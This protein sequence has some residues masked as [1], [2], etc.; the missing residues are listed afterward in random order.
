VAFSPDGQRLAS[1]S[2]DR[3]VRLWDAT[4]GQEVINLGGHTGAVRSV[5]FSPDGRRLA[6]ASDDTT[7]RLWD[8][9]LG[10]VSFMLEGAW[11]HEG[12]QSLDEDF[13]REIARQQLE[14][15]A[16]EEIPR[17]NHSAASI[18]GGIKYVFER[19]DMKEYRFRGSKTMAIGTGQQSFV[20][21]GDSAAQVYYKVEKR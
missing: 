20:A 9:T 3:T 18:S 12:V 10:L 21:W 13:L 2:W 14:A 8:A 15:K 17:W 1:T 6:S 7:V 11:R 19:V 4:T 5:A 16:R